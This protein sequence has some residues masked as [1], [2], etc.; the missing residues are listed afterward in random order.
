MCNIT[1][2]LLSNHPS[3]AETINCIHHCC[4]VYSCNPELKRNKRIIFQATQKCPYTYGSFFE[5]VCMRSSVNKYRSTAVTYEMCQQHETLC[6][7]YNVVH[8][9]HPKKEKR[10]ILPMSAP[11][12]PSLMVME[13]VWEACTGSTCQERKWPPP[14]PLLMAGSRKPVLPGREGGGRR[15]KSQKKGKSFGQSFLAVEY[16]AMDLYLRG[17]LKG[18]KH[19]MSEFIACDFRSW[20]PV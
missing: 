18:Q 12:T 6:T 16:F 9:S 1:W 20:I 19:L 17:E 5:F 4:I 3:H 11:P 7:L 8:I 15:A 13:A 2:G 10:T 14:P